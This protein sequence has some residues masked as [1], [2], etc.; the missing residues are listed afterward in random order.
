M[1]TSTGKVLHPIEQFQESGDSDEDEPLLSGTG[2]VCKESGQEK[3]D[4]WSNL[5]SVWEGNPKPKEVDVL[6]QNHGVPQVSRVAI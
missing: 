1:T 5:I 3:L 6:I 2:L 4:E